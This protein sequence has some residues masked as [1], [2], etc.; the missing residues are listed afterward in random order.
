MGDRI[1]KAN[2]FMKTVR[3][4]RK[5][6]L[7]RTYYAARERIAQERDADYRYSEP[8]AETLAGQ[9]ASSA[10]NAVR[11]SV[12]VPAYETDE[13]F[14]REMLDSVCRQSYAG[15][16]LIVADAS[17]SDTVERTVGQIAA[18]RGDGR[19]RYFRLA[20][21]QGIAANTN[22]GIAL[23][24]GDYIAFLDHDDLLAPDA[25]YRM[26]EAVRRARESGT[27]P[28]MLYSDEDKYD[29]SGHC[30]TAPHRKTEF[31]LDLLLSN[32]Y[33]CHFMAVESGLCRRL[34]LRRHFDG[35]QD[36]DLALRIAGKLYDEA[37]RQDMAAGIVHVP[38]IL[39][40]WRCHAGST[41]DNTASKTYA[42]EAGRAALADFCAAR[43]WQV[44]VE[45]GLH[46]GFYEITYLPDVFAVRAD[47]GIVGGRIWDQKKRICGGALK[48]DGS[49]MY[50]GLHREYSGGT[51][52]RAA[53]QQ[54]VAAADIRC[55]QVREELREEFMRITGL[56]Y[57]ERTVRCGS[58]RNARQVRVADVSGLA[59]DEAGWRKLS[60]ELGRAAARRGYRIL[61]D[62]RIGIRADR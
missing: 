16:E 13:V 6:G 59:C 4:F 46:L 5:N 37:P 9:R 35:A 55:V 45:H 39:Y 30:Y 3:Y 31:N 42:Y 34:P 51:S 8:S 27:I 14:L 10:G 36:Y 41:A 21:N 50:E 32:N 57:T 24:T 19:I 49:V 48:S 44:Q 40:H 56:P 62:P 52:H 7:R 26:A 38:E 18:E 28:A 2:N 29:G 61:W 33:I 54:D 43:G 23:A 53:V 15:W 17:D 47:V 58:G 11:F 60:L 20:D 1:L 22:A 25:F 12:V